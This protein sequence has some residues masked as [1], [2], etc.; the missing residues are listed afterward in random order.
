MTTDIGNTFR[1]N[2]EEGKNASTTGNVYGV[3]DMAGG[4][5]EYVAGYLSDVTPLTNYTLLASAD[6]KYKDKYVGTSDT[7]TVNYELNKNKYGDAMYETSTSGTGST[8]WDSDCSLFT[9]DSYPVFLHGGRALNNNIAGV[10]AF[11]RG[12]GDSYTYIGF[13][14]CLVVT[15]L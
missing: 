15:Q 7:D 1:Y 11:T 14:P 2:T 5:W 13:R 12:T 4:A 10:F 3:Y 6:D 9:V 8:S